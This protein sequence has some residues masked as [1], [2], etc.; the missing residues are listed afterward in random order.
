MNVKNS[1]STGP[2]SIK[3][4]ATS[5]VFPPPDV[6]SLP[7]VR[8]DAVFP[9]GRI[10]CVGRNYEDHAIEMGAVADR[11]APFFFTKSSSACTESGAAIPY[12]PGTGNYHHEV[13]LVVAIGKPTFGVAK[14]AALEAVFGY[15]CGLDMTRRDLQLSARD[16]GRPWDLGK[17]FEQS[18]I[19]GP[20]RPVTN[21]SHPAAGRIELSVNDEVRQSSDIGLMIH[22]VAEIIVYLSTFYHLEPG[23]LIFTGTPHGVGPLVAGDRIEG[24]IE[25]VGTVSLSVL[26][27]D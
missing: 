25:G 10:F 13:E 27:A 2:D 7:I 11:E 24:S 22:P 20:I 26:P 16:R 15:A 17:D 23:D 1:K 14:E 9:V 8:R 5:F 12:P 21:Q 3:K 6:V 19:V 18:A 4:R